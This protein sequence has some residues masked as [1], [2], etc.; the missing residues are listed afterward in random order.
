MPRDNLLNSAC[1]ELFETIRRENVKPII[2]HLVETYRER[3]DAITYVDT[4]RNIIARYEQ[5][6][7][8][9]GLPHSLNNGADPD[10]SFMTSDGDTPNTRRVIVNG[11][12]SRWQGLKDTDA[13]EEAYFNTSDGDD[14]DDEDE[15]AME[16]VRSTTATTTR[17][18]NGASPLSKPLVDYVD[19]DEDNDTDEF[20][21]EAQL[22]LLKKVAS[23]PVDQQTT[24][25]SSF[26]AEELQCL[27]PSS[28]F[29]LSLLDTPARKTPTPPPS[30]PPTTSTTTLSH[31]PS[32][33]SEKRRR[34]EDDDDDELGRLA[35]VSTSSP[36]GSVIAP[37][38]RLSSSVASD[39]SWDIVSGASDNGSPDA[40][41]S[42]TTATRTM[43]VAGGGSVL[44]SEKAAVASAPRQ[45]LRRKKAFGPAG[46]EGA[47]SGG[48][49]AKKI[50]FSLGAGVVKGGKE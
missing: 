38:R 2:L 35:S 13:D 18:I 6:T 50:A 25:A 30:T 31:P 37:K 4:F 16:G 49:G 33:L 36:A 27:S 17:P 9:Q 3:L 41:T 32:H 26:S 1:L 29:G 10:S 44:D 48:V 22:E 11:G 15:L 19:D 40:R 39:A 46:K 12:G 28:S 21:A 5:L 7:H 24:L 34:D 43:T 8:P 45:S 23:N 42:T 14:D 20:D 47:S